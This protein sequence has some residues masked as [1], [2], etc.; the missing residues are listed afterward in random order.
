MNRRTKALAIPAAVK[1]RVRERDGGLCVLCGRPGEPVCHFISRAQA[2]LGIEENIWTGCVEC[3]RAYDQ[4]I[5]RYQIRQRLA[6]Y[7]RSKY[8]G[9]DDLTLVYKKGG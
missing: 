8:P 5:N 6:G 2:G 4:G 1:R 7:F 9:W 3:H